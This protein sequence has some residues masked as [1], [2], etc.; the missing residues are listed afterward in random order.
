MHRKMCIFILFALAHLTESMEQRTYPIIIT[1]VVVIVVALF[2]LS[3]CLVLLVFVS[4]S[5]SFMCGAGEC[6][7]F[8]LSHSLSICVFFPTAAR[9]CTYSELFFSI[10]PKTFTWC[11]FGLFTFSFHILYYNYHPYTHG[12]GI[13]S[14]VH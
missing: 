1:V 5:K 9:V 4:F 8:S 14:V 2:L 3:F 10:A 13:L 6:M 12:N 7:L 11:E